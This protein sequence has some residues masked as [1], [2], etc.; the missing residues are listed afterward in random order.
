MVFFVKKSS[1][2]NQRWEM[3]GYW[4]QALLR[5]EKTKPKIDVLTSLLPEDH[6]KF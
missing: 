5:K 2:D 1:F 3:G 4:C 6:K